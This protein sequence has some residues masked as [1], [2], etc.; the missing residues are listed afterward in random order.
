MPACALQRNGR[1]LTYPVPSPR[2]ASRGDGVRDL[3]LIRKGSKR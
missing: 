3:T 1:G 2:P